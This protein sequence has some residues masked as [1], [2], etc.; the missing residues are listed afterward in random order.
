MY[1]LRDREGNAVAA[2]C[3]RRNVTA[4]RELETEMLT[5]HHQLLALSRISSAVAGLSHLDDILNVALDTVLEIVN[6]T[7]GGILLL[8]ERTQELTYRV[9][10]GLSA[11][12]AEEMR[13]KVGEG[14]SG[15]VAQTGEPVLLQDVS[16][17]PR[18]ARL[19]LV[20]A[21]GLK[22]FVG[23]PLRAKN[24]VLGVMNIASHLPGEFAEEDKYLLDSIGHQLGVAI[25]QAE[26]YERLRDANESYQRLLQHAM[27]AQE[28]ERKR[29]ARELHDSTSQML[30]SD[31]ADQ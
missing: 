19:D 6:G 7:I 9:Q 5:R 22:S 31:Q 27:T 11:K 10:R 4:E 18:T 26:L 13:L 14:I 1:P 16:L 23:V 8:D 21:E 20:S 30:T 29:I 25:E 28:A 2:V 17:D 12:Y 24:R 3:L 15:T